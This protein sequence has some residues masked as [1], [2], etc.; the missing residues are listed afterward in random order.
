MAVKRI[1][2]E[3]QTLTVPKGKVLGIVDTRAQ[4]DAVV[5]GLKSAGFNTIESLSGE[6]GVQL[7]ERINAFFFSDMADKMRTVR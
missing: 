6:E 7:L 4:L 2:D 5:G 1:R 3:G